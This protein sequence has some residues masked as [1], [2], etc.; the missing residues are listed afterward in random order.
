MPPT[1]KGSKLIKYLAIIHR[2]FTNPQLVHFEKSIPPTKVNKFD[3]ITTN[4]S[5]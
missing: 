3:G 4:K 1:I 2:C 5:M